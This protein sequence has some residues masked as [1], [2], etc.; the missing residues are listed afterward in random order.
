[1]RY[2]AFSERDPAVRNAS[3]PPGEQDLGLWLHRAPGEP[4]PL[5]LSRWR[6]AK[7]IALGKN[8][9]DPERV[10][11]YEVRAQRHQ[12]KWFRSR[13]QGRCGPSRWARRWESTPSAWSPR[14]CA[15]CGTTAKMSPG[16]K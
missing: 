3:L 13:V 1:M 14:R 9:V 6:S 2:D 4:H 16:L 12:Q 15:S 7:P 5:E 10:A 11:A 8:M